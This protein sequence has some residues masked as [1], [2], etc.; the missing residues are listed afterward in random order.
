[1]YL[2]IYIYT[3]FLA[4]TRRLV[5]YLTLYQTNNNLK[6]KTLINKQLL[7]ETIFITVLNIHTW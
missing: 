3:Y 2:F 1:M 7:F 5:I 4:Y 6:K